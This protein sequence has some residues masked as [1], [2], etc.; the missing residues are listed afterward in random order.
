MA[1]IG[2]QRDQASHER[3]LA[4]ED[5]READR[6]DDRREAERLRDSAARHTDAANAHEERAVEQVEELE[7]E[8]P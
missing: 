4:R 1:D 2:R 6:A 3:R 5:R 7:G 8:T